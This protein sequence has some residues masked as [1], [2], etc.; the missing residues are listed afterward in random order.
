[1]VSETARQEFEKWLGEET[2]PVHWDNSAETNARYGYEAGYLA[3]CQAERAPVC[4][5]CKHSLANND[6]GFDQN[7]AMMDDDKLVHSGSCTYC[8]ECNP[9][10]AE[11]IRAQGEERL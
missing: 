8:N 7:D 3:G 5:L 4:D 1:M 11:A 2:C 6:H 9:S 10:L